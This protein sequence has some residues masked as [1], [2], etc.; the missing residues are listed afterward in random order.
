MNGIGEARPDPARSWTSGGRGFWVVV[1][2]LAFPLSLEP[3]VQE[4]NDAKHWLPE[5]G[6]TRSWTC[7][8][9]SQSPN[10]CDRGLVYVRGSV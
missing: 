4:T 2:V 6:S 3:S 9:R 10:V 1:L 8:L 5:R 7:S